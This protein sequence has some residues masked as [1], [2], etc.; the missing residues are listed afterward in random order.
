MSC[1]SAPDTTHQCCPAVAPI[2]V[3]SHCCPSV[4]PHQCP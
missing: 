4:P 1:Q 2:S 3:A